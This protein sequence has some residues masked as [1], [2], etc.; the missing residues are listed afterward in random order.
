MLG[1]HF[2]QDPGRRAVAVY[3][4][5]GL[6]VGIIIAGAAIYFFPAQTARPPGGGK[7]HFTVSKETTYIIG[8]LEGEGWPDYV[9]ALNERLKQG[10]TVEN[11][12]AV[13]LW[14]AHG[15]RP[16]GGKLPPEFFQYLG[17]PEPPEQGDYFV[18]LWRY[19]REHLQKE[20]SAA[21][22]EQLERARLRP[23]KAEQLPLAAAWLRLNDKP[24]AVVIEAS[25]RSQY[26]SPLVASANERAPKSLNYT[27]V[28]HVQL[29]RQFAAALTARAA[30]RVGEGRFDEAWQDLLACHRLARHVAHGG[31]VVEKLVAVA[32]ESL[33]AEADVMFLD[34]TR[35]EAKQL[36]A[37]LHDLQQLPP[38]PSMADSLDLFA[39]LTFL[40][41]VTLVDRHGLPYVEKLGGNG[42]GW[43]D[44]GRALK[45]WQ[46]K[47]N[48]DPALRNGN[49]I[50]DRLA[51]AV[52][53]PDRAARENQVRQIRIDLQGVKAGVAQ[54]LAMALEDPDITPESRGQVLGDVLLSLL[55]PAVEGTYLAGDRTE[56]IGRNLQVAFALA[57]F[58]RDHGKY[59][60]KLEELTPRYLAAVPQD[61]FS[62][63]PLAYRPEAD[64]FLLY[65]VGVNGQDD[66]GHSYDDDPPGDDLR[67]RLPL[68]P[69]K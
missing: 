23:W 14:K 45:Q 30:L 42:N 24:L 69:L 54:S 51:A 46:D 64:G 66:Q 60:Q 38:L 63:K 27:L 7:P 26:F 56:Q 49:R 17:I 55:V 16:E 8:P 21:V 53:L 20:T 25:K 33:A 52:R 5:A 6:G 18:N 1:L 35:L 22:D 41:T 48:W 40:E 50:F 68:P 28:P 57:A 37:C 67:V 44:L 13:L 15:P 2:P 12:A 36:Q 11:N 4:L 43:K 32:I 10:V 65:S 9:A 31:S 61:L 29:C 34:S 3:L 47:I 62:G 58:Q 19:S 59:P 39:R